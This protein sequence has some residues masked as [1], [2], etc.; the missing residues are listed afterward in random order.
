MGAGRQPQRGRGGCRGACAPEGRVRLGAAA[1]GGG[2]RAGRGV[3]LCMAPRSTS[4]RVCASAE[5]SSAAR[6]QESIVAGCAWV[7]ERR[8]DCCGAAGCALCTRPS[9]A[10]LSCRVQLLRRR[11][12]GSNGERREVGCGG[13]GCVTFESRR[14]ALRCHR[15]L[16][17][18]EGLVGGAGCHSPNEPRT[19]LT[20]LCP[21][22]WALPSSWRAAGALL[23]GDYVHTADEYAR[24]AARCCCARMVRGG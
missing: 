8:F 23:C 21:A 15:P 13:V 4:A 24:H 10:C 19:L 5:A 1:C 16:S 18:R 7:R 12:V 14:Q 2:A 9:A 20:L 22:W 11:S 17:W 6:G 3:A